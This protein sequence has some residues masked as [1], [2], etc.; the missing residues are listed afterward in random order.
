MD[1]WKEFLHNNEFSC[2][3]VCSFVR[4][5]FSIP[6]NTGWVERLYSIL[7]NIC[8]KRRNQLAIS[9][10]SLLFFLAVLKLPVKESQE[11]KDEIKTLNMALY[12]ALRQILCWDNFVG[13]NQ[14]KRNCFS[15]N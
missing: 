11:Y 15:F 10:M 14:E 4:I 3:D 7:E 8:Q 5:L 13:K 12:I 6:A 1:L 9:T 2:G